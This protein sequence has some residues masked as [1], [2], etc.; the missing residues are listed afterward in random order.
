MRL[1]LASYGRRVFT[2]DAQGKRIGE[3]APLLQDLM[4]GTVS[5]RG[6]GGPAWLS[7]LHE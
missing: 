4:S 2:Q 5:G 7:Q 6:P 3:D 1:S